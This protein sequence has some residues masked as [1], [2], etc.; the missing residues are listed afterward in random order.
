MHMKAGLFKEVQV[1][2][3]HVHLY[4]DSDYTYTDLECTMKYQI[5][6]KAYTYQD[7]ITVKDFNTYAHQPVLYIS[8]YGD[9]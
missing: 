8:D 6:T 5:S 1:I 3:T 9:S 4:I 7:S 2:S